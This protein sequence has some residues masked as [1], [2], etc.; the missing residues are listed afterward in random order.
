MF[1]DCVLAAVCS[2]AEG[3]GERGAGDN[4]SGLLGYFA[5]AACGPSRGICG[6]KTL[7]K[8]REVVADR[9]VRCAGAGVG[10]Y[11]VKS[12]KLQ[13]YFRFL[14]ATDLVP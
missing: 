8:Q 11:V 1:C 4:L 14:D 2:V 9:G 6:R 10:I 7:A 3:H 12:L 13:I 5:L